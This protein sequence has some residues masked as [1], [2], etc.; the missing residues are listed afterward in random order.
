MKRWLA[1]GRCPVAWCLCDAGSGGVPDETA[2]QPS[3]ERPSAQAGPSAEAQRARR[4]R[5]SWHQA[6]D[7]AGQ[8]PTS[9]LLAWG[10]SGT[11][12][13]L[14]LAGRRR[15]SEVKRR[16]RHPGRG[17]TLPFRLGDFVRKTAAPGLDCATVTPNARCACGN[18]AKNHHRFQR[19]PQVVR[20]QGIEYLWPILV[21]RKPANAFVK[22]MK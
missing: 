11:A 19:L 14:S 10:R 1:L 17:R 3:T 6:A 9:R 8:R 13:R 20:G 12:D 21:G 7:A 22:R 16:C 18:R 15:A 4:R 5:N 2:G